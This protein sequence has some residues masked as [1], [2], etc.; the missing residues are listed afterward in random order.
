[1]ISH[2]VDVPTSSQVEPTLSEFD[3]KMAERQKVADRVD[4]GPVIQASLVSE[5]IIKDD[6]RPV[7]SFMQEFEKG[8][9]RV[10]RSSG[11]VDITCCDSVWFDCVLFCSHCL[12]V[13]QEA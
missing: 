10:G 3:K 8:K 7:P 12:I 6:D 4:A 13:R 1:M 5:E 9:R 2:F 11:G